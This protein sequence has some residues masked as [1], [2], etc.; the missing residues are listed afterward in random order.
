MLSGINDE[1]RSLKKRASRTL[2]LNYSRTCI[3]RIGIN[4]I[5][6][7]VGFFKSHFLK[8]GILHISK[9]DNRLSRM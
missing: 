3:S 9:S 8:I 6:A 1:I 5:I 4:R 2:R 7:Y